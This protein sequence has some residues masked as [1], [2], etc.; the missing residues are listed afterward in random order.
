M[1]FAFPNS[2]RCEHDLLWSLDSKRKKND[3]ENFKKTLFKQKKGKWKRKCCD[4]VG[5][6]L[7]IRTRKGLLGKKKYFIYL[8]FETT[9]NRKRVVLKKI[10][11]EIQ[12]IIPFF[13]LPNKNGKG[14]WNKKKHFF[15]FSALSNFVV[16]LLFYGPFEFFCRFFPENV[17]T[18]LNLKVIAP[19]EKF[20]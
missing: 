11:N 8:P 17:L 19:F 4:A 3:G 6:P 10:K 13:F 7:F 15:F 14:K 2:E 1:G 20:K 18:S 16:R 5:L 12:G 9:K